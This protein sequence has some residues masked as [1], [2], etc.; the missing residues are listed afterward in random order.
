VDASAIRINERRLQKDLCDLGSFGEVLSGGLMRT[1]LSNADLEARRW[2]KSR[3]E[4]AGLRVREDAVANLIGRLDPPAVSPSSSCIG[5]GSHI[6]SVPNG[7]KFDG[8][9]GLCVG[10]EAVRAIRESGLS[11]PC[12]LELLVFTD[13]EGSHYAG[14][15][16]SR[17]MLDLL[18][19]GEIYRSRSEDQPSLSAD[20]LRIGKDPARIAEA[21]RQPTE[22]CAFLEVHIEQGPILNAMNIP[23]GIVEGVVFLERHIIRVVGQSG[24]AGTTPMQLRDDAL[25]KAARIITGVHEVLVHSGTDMVGTIGNLQVFPGVFN[26]IP[27]RVDMFLDLRAMDELT[28]D[29]G[30]NTIREI[31]AS[32]TNAQ[33]ELILSKGGISMD[34]DIMQALEDSCRERAIPCTRMGS[35]AGHDAMSFQTRGIPTGMIFIPCEEGKSHGP[36]EAIRWEDATRSAQV[37]AD[38]VMR[39]GFGEKR[40][41]GLGS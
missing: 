41:K 26:I 30:R 6:D 19:E 22:F 32:E 40:E 38:S 3:M 15:F 1:A 27:G 23:I 18:L 33:A 14:T 20:L 39:I 2:F 31:V 8:G 13:E 28:L 4:E 21:I 11:F 16:G 25:V 34:A 5:V 9:L 29:S 12:P 7:G 24:H 36:E 37:L 10:L 35:G 17:A